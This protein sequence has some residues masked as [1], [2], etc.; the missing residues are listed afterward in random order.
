MKKYRGVE[1]G[2]HAFYTSAFREGECSVEVTE[3]RSR[4]QF[5][6]N[7]RGPTDTD[8]DFLEFEFVIN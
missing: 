6:Y 5:G 1:V 8:F 2:L 4:Y 3:R 7:V